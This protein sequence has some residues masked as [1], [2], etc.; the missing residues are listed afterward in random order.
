MAMF[1]NEVLSWDAVVY[2]NKDMKLD[3]N[4]IVRQDALLFHSSNIC[5]GVIISREGRS[6][7]TSERE[8]HY[9]PQ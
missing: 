7:D 1:K 5:L 3:P 6:K 9:Q 4:N 8:G 2:Q